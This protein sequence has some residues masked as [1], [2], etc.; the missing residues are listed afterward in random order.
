MEKERDSFSLSALLPRTLRTVVL[1]YLA[2]PKMPSLHRFPSFSVVHIPVPR[3]YTHS[4]SLYASI[5]YIIPQSHQLFTSRTLKDRHSL[6]LGPPV[7]IAFVIKYILFFT[8]SYTFLFLLY[9]RAD[10]AGQPSPVLIFFGLPYNPRIVHITIS[11]PEYPIG[12]FFHLPIFCSSHCYGYS[13][14]GPHT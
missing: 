10:G 14:K 8:L 5:V 12:T 9:L 3:L 2:L 4:L 13:C 6:N 1:L 11:S 7:T